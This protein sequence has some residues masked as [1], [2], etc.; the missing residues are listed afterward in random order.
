MALS[1]P[2][3]R[4]LAGAMALGGAGLL[5]AAPSLVAVPGF[6]LR[7]S[8]RLAGIGRGDHIALTF[9]DG[10]DSASTPSVL[11][12]LDRLGWHAT[13]FMLGA[14]VERAP[15]LAAEVAAAGHEVAVHGHIHLSELRRPPRRVLEDLRRARGVIA[16]ATG[17]APAWFRPPYGIATSSGLWAARRA[18]IPMVLWTCWGRDWRIEATADSI[19]ADI[20]TD[21]RPGATVLLHDSDCT[22]EPGS[23]RATVDALPR[24][25]E[26]W[27]GSG[28]QVGALRDHGLGDLATA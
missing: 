19:V 8:P 20:E 5:H 1:R 26:R 17:C 10:P 24:L 2:V 23:W 18:G 15:A 9:D 22:S 13:F 28:W 12:A 25:A 7:F 11:A 4:A 3:R 6:R 21:L 16:E 14:M 27:E